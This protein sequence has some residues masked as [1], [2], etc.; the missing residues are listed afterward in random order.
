MRILQLSLLFILFISISCLNNKSNLN[1]KDSFDEAGFKSINMVGTYEGNLPCVDCDGIVTLLS[2]NKD[3]TYEMNYTYAGKSNE[4]F[5]KK[6]N[7]YIDEGI[8]T[9]EG[10]DYVY[11]IGNNSITQ[12]DLSGKEISGQLAEQ[13]ELKKIMD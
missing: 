13:Y 9:L 5:N 8:L 10:E 4:T 7:W 3:K 1:A 2:L 12:L 11:K 6:G